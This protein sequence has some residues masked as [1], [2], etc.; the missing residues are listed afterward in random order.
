M[1]K[2]QSLSGLQ[3]ASSKSKKARRFSR[4]QYLQKDQGKSEADH[5][6][7]KYIRIEIRENN[8]NFSVLL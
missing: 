1:D 3:S 4:S 7:E 5:R 2:G 6:Q 8:K